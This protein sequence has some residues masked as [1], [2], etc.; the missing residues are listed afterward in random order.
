MNIQSSAW[1]RETL[2]EESCSVPWKFNLLLIGNF[3][4]TYLSHLVYNQTYWEQWWVVDFFIYEYSRIFNLL[5]WKK[6]WTFL[7][8]NVLLPKNLDELN[9]PSHRMWKLVVALI[10]V[11]AIVSISVLFS[12]K[13]L[14]IF[15]HNNAWMDLN[16]AL[17]TLCP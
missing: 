17:M 14:W 1:K 15:I 9:D 7:Y 2:I 11:I 3:I 6:K 8:E 16:S 5:L 4:P 10:V 13:K 12:I